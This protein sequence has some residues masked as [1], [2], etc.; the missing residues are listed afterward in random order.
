LFVAISRMLWAF[1]FSRRRDASGNLIPIDRDALTQGL[2]V[3]P[4]PFE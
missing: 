4:A 3:Q 1:N 2:I